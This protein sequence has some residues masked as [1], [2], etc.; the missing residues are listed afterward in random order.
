MRK[1]KRNVWFIVNPISGTTG[2]ERIVSLIPEYL[3]ESDFRV[4]VCYTKYGG[5]AAKYAAQ[6]VAKHAD[7]VVAVGGDGTVNEVARSLIHTPT[8][9]GIVPCGSGNGLARHLSIPLNPEGALQVIGQ[10]VIGEMDYGRING[11][12]FFCT[13]GV[14]FDAFV[15]SKFAESGRRGL[16]TYIE[17]T[18][19]QGLQYKPETYDIEIDDE[20]GGTRH[21]KA[22][23]IA[24][25]NASQ[26]GNNVYIAPSASMSDGLM[27]IT[28]MEPFTVL[29]A[30]QIAIQLFSKTIG[31]NSR[32]Q[33]FR[34][35]RLVIHRKQAGVIHFDGDPKQESADLEIELI[36]H[37][38]RMVVNPDQKPAT[39]PLLRMF[40][41][42]YNDMNAEWAQLR[43][44]IRET[45]RR[46]RT[47]NKELLNKLRPQ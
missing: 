10:C 17:N 22:F 19:V 2:K 35:R 37:D 3:P 31:R 43:Q 38:I 36:P 25:A 21:C 15:S 1:K 16:L 9:L 47:I 12:P 24:C 30:P 28:I 41:D 11:T 32:I 33:T 6:A 45:P 27:D 18:L 8:A 44:D 34:C 42:L 14:G 40:T 26:Y 20:D 46:I 7:V 23:L 5:H 39:P 29:E 13:C 4:R